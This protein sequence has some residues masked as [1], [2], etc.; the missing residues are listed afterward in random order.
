MTE[1]NFSKFDKGSTRAAEKPE[2]TI[3][4]KGAVVLN[5]PAH[6]LMG[7]PSAVE[8]LYDE[9]QAVI[10]L[11]TAPPDDPDAHRLRATGKDTRFTIAAAPFLKYFDIPFGDPVKREVRMAGDVLVLDLK[12]PGRD[13]TSNRRRERFED[14]AKRLVDEVER[15]R[16]RKQPK[17]S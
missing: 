5:G 7:E 3:Q 14:L 16:Q 4:S 1:L 9:D 12:D 2:V 11:R 10:G 8:L 13:A 17:A 15:A 6:R